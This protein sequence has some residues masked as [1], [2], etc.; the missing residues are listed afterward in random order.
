[1]FTV[2]GFAIPVF[3]LGIVYFIS[4]DV[5]IALAPIFFLLYAI[6]AIVYV[7]ILMAFYAESKGKSPWIWSIIAISIV[8]GILITIFIIDP[9]YT[10]LGL[11]LAPLLSILLT[12]VFIKI[13]E[14]KKS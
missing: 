4:V 8:V 11:F 13:S 9:Q 10:I 3:F 1:V 12:M 6:A 7:S 14:R 5:F 2:I